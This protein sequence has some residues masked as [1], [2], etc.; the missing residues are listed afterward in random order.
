MHSRI[1]M[2]LTYLEQEGMQL[3]RSHAMPPFMSFEVS[4]FCKCLNSLPFIKIL[5]RCITIV[6]TRV[7]LQ[8]DT[9]HLPYSRMLFGKTLLRILFRTFMV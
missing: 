9:E 4:T 8:H 1:N 3:S 6:M 2:K 5:L 7:R